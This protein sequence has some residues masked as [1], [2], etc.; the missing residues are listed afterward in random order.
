[1]LAGE[2]GGRVHREFTLSGH[3]VQ[4]AARLEDVS[5]RGQIYVGDLTFER[6][7]TLFSYRPVEPVALHGSVDTV[8][9]YELLA[10]AD[11]RRR[12]KRDSERRQATV[13]SAEIVGLAVLR[14]THS[15]EEQTDI[16]NHCFAA[17]EAAV[18]EFGG[19]IDKFIGAGLMALFGVPTAIE[20]AP[21][22]ALN[23][24][25]AMGSGCG[26]PSSIWRYR[27][28][29]GSTWASTRVSSSP[30]RSVVACGAAS[31]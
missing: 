29:C 12:R 5:D 27:S 13:M 6:T 7:R 1:M 30:A 17:L 4:L 15:A 10:I 24:A 21:R 3:T 11:A 9:A 26:G 23:A 31:R 2:V 16:L 8:P 14:D 19:C 28:N 20:N 22:Q 18:V 25:V